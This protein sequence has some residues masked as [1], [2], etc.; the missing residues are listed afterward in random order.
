MDSELSAERLGGRMLRLLPS[1]VDCSVFFA[2][3][4]KTVVDCSVYKFGSVTC[5]DSS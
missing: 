1:V 4:W 3:R 5:R 2:C